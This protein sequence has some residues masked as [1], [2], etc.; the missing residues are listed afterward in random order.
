MLKKEIT[1][2]NEDGEIVK[3]IFYF[4]LTR[5]ETVKVTIVEDLER[6]A[7]STD[8]KAI[9]PV[10]ENVIRATYGVRQGDGRFVKRKEDT[11]WFISSDAYSELF[12]DL[13]KDGED[14]VSAFIRAVI[15]SATRPGE[16]QTPDRAEPQDFRQPAPSAR[17][18]FEVR[19]SEGT[20]AQPEW[21]SDRHR[22]ESAPV[23]Q[24]QGVE[25]SPE[26]GPTPEEL[27][28]WRAQRRAEAQQDGAISRPPH[29]YGSQD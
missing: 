4:N 22:V 19:K 2:E 10:F 23:Q 27:A 17:E 3:G 11:D 16:A 1:Y 21:P 26:D 14:G 8:P 24:N 20:P 9:L 6:I 29:E 15:P 18:Q 7:E 12:L 13:L 28:A 25:A 5:A